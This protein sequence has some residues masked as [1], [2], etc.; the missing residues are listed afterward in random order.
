MEDLIEVNDKKKLFN[1]NVCEIKS[2][3]NLMSIE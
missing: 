2:L 3:L 1:F